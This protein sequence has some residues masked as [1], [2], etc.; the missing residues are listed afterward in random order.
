MCNF[1]R[2]NCCDFTIDALTEILDAILTSSITFTL[3][4]FA[5]T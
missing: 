5:D 3:E 4:N 1:K 2:M